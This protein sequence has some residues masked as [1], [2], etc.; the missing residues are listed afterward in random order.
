KYV[1]NSD[2]FSHFFIQ[3]YTLHVNL[4]FNKELVV[5]KVKYNNLVNSLLVTFKVQ[6]RRETE[7]TSD[8]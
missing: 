1:E 3:K 2:V 5:L 7:R 4:I 6:E 8:N